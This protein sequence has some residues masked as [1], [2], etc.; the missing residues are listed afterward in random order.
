[1]NRNKWILFFVFPVI[2]LP[3]C[4]TSKSIQRQM[5]GIKSELFYE[6][7]TSL[8]PGNIENAIYLNPVCD[9]AILPYTIV[10]KKGFV[11][12]PFV[13]YNHV[14][15]KF[16]VTLGNGSLIQA[17]SEFL[18]DAL[19]AECNRSSCFDLIVNDDLVLPD[20]AMVLEVKV[21][22]N[23]T[24]A[25]LI[26]NGGIFLNPFMDWQFEGFSNWKTTQPVSRLEISVRLIQQENC[27]F[28][29]TYALAHDISC[30]HSGIEEPFNAYTICIEEMAYCLSQTTK[31]VVE[32][33]SQELNLL[34]LAKK[35][36]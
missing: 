9:S 7:T 26:S 21:N 30:Q 22:K 34:M 16:E 31:R 28:E 32:N 19:L 18:V 25:Q 6:L 1:M 27:L 10:K 17:Y 29:K 24:T 33:I 23:T 12:I 15:E 4:N 3:A 11:L 5:L 13:V 20:S 35:V 14:R 2:L 8:Y 36:N